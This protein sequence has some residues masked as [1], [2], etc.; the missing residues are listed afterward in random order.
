MRYKTRITAPHNLDWNSDIMA[1]NE[2][3]LTKGE[4]RKLNALRK[5]IGD[6]L[7]DEAFSKWLKQHNSKKTKAKADPIAAKIAEAMKPLAKAKALNLGRYGYVVK[8]ARGKGAKGIIVSR[9]EKV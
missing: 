4:I 2:A 1:I 5:S 9:I 6:G 8:R 7:A 3:A